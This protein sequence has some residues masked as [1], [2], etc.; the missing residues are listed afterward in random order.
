MTNTSIKNIQLQNNRTIAIQAC[1]VC[2]LFKSLFCMRGIQIP[3]PVLLSVK[4]EWIHRISDK[5]EQEI[6]HASFDGTQK[7]SS[8]LLLFIPSWYHF[9]V[10]SVESPSRKEKG[11]KSSLWR[12]HIRGMS[13]CAS[14]RTWYTGNYFITTLFSTRITSRK[15][16]DH[17]YSIILFPYFIAPK[18]GALQTRLS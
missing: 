6:F 12:F 18:S 14:L 8:T 7:K 13:I 16:S 9:R 17:I 15:L 11:L 3:S 1:F 10:Y 5:Y 4:T 2:V